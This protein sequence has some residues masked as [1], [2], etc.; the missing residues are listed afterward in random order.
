[1]V[2]PG[3]TVRFAA[4]AAGRFKQIPE[5]K[6]QSD[7]GTRAYYKRLDKE[8]G[9]RAMMAG[10]EFTIVDIT[11]MCMIDFGATLVNLA[12]DPEL[13]NLARWREE[14]ASRPSSSA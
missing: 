11:A 10:D 3:L 5:A 4:A 2:R 13:K 9:T 7:A 1:M 6:E 8:L 12:P 14:V